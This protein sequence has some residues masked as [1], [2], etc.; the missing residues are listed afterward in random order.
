M[1]PSG[2]SLKKIG[3]GL[4]TYIQ[5]TIPTTYTQDLR[6]NLVIAVGG[7]PLRPR[8]LFFEINKSHAAIETG[9]CSGNGCAFRGRVLD[10]AG[11]RQK[12]Q[13]GQFGRGARFL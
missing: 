9:H 2:L 5:E 8:F 4:V 13:P 3:I 6:Y 12:A 10:D 11:D 1:F 7:W